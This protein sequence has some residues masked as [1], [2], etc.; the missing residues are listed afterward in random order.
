[1]VIKWR[2]FAFSP[3]FDNLTIQRKRLKWLF[4][5]DYTVEIFVPPE[6]RKYWLLVLPILLG[7]RLIGRMDVKALRA[8][9][10]LVIHHLAFEPNFRDWNAV[11]SSFADA[12]MHFTRFQGCD[13]WKIT[14]VEPKAFKVE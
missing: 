9:R 1:M 4:D 8:E 6:K 5:F 14:R 10:Q 3:L 7:D 12:L 2:S 13:D 11:K